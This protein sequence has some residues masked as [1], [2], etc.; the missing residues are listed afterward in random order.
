MVGPEAFT[1]VR[2]LAHAHHLQALGVIDRV[3]KEYEEIIGRKS[4]GL[5]DLYRA[6]DAEVM[7]VALGSVIGTIKDVIERNAAKTGK[8]VR[9][10]SASSP[11]VLSLLPKFLPPLKALRPRL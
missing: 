8:K 11:I 6:E 1:E 7:V 9:V 2:Y 3:A 5:L 4:G 10:F